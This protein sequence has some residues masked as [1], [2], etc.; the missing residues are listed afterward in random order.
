M[1]RHLADKRSATDG[2]R[3]RYFFKIARTDENE[4]PD[5]RIRKIHQRPV[6]RDT[7]A[8]LDNFFQIERGRRV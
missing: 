5:A 7:P 2:G 8:R 1:S 3:V 4:G 6:N